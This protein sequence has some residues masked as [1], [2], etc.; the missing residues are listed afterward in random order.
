[1]LTF[2][3]MIDEMSV[4]SD[5]L[6]QHVQISYEL[7]QHLSEVILG[8]VVLLCFVCSVCVIEPCTKC[9]LVFEFCSVLWLSIVLKNEG[10]ETCALLCKSFLV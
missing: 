10:F 3:F 2:D 8:H 6:L 7:F 1:M 4:I 9:F 5:A